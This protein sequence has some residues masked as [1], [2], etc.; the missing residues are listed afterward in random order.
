[1]QP[2]YLAALSWRLLC[3][4]SPKISFVLFNC[5]PIICGP[6]RRLSVVFS[7]PM[8]LLAVSA[9]SPVL[10]H[11]W[12]AFTRV[13][14]GSVLSEVTG[15]HSALTQL[16][17]STGLPVCPPGNVCPTFSHC[18]V[19]LAKS[20]GHQWCVQTPASWESGPSAVSLRG[21]TLALTS[22]Q[23]TFNFSEIHF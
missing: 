3:V 1:M 23:E 21:M 7:L 5:H 11:V 22:Q 9:W 2:C 19:A 13:C 10:A 8:Y 14:L 15:R 18:L 6:S 17:F 16:P 4:S 20:A 12:Y